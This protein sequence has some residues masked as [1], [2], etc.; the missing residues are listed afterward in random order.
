MRSFSHSGSSLIS[1]GSREY[2]SSDV[3]RLKW[4]F[5]WKLG[6]VPDLA[7]FGFF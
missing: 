6:D 2:L 1:F 7:V 4:Q 5:A 3:W